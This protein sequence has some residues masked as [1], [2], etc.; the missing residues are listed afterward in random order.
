MMVVVVGELRLKF[1]LGCCQ[2]TLY[3]ITDD[4][5]G[6][7]EEK[8]ENAVFEVT[9]NMHFSILM[10]DI[11]PLGKALSSDKPHLGASCSNF[12][13][14][15]NVLNIGKKKNHTTFRGKII[16]TVADFWMENIKPE[17]KWNDI[18]KWIKRKKIA[19]SEFYSQQ[20]WNKALL[21]KQYL[22]ASVTNNQHCT[23]F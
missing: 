18:L 2:N 23:K 11:N 4:R 22:R 3:R 13:N 17:D 21:D 7:K 15:D 6:E 8:I 12:W 1:Y 16:K 19:N 5:K 9:I 20:S 10:K 14:K